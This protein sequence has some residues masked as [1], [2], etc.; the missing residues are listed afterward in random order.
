VGARDATLQNSVAFRNL[1]PAGKAAA[2]SR[3]W[4]PDWCV[5]H[6]FDARRQWGYGDYTRKENRGEPCF[7]KYFL[8]RS[9]V[10]KATK[11]FV[12][13]LPNFLIEPLKNV[14]L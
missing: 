2:R 8:S 4:R 10:I 3:G 14:R 1:G 5:W 11:L 12:I 9:L 13:D 6:S 7:P